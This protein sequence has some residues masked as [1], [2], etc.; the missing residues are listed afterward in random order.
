MSETTSSF[1]KGYSIVAVLLFIISVILLFAISNDNS[2]LR[3][4]KNGWSA[5]FSNADKYMWFWILSLMFFTLY[6]LTE[7]LTKFNKKKSIL[8]LD[9]G[10]A[11][12]ALATILAVILVKDTTYKMLGI[13]LVIDVIVGLVL[14]FLHRKVYSTEV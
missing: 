12:M 14:H 6:G 3:Q 9:S 2:S 13:F 11:V 5:D 4:L 7:F 10:I 1:K 8:F